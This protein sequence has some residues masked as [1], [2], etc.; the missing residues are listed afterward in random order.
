VIAWL[1]NLFGADG[2]SAVGTA[3]ADAPPTI[4]RVNPAAPNA[5]TALVT[6]FFFEACFTRGIVA[7][8]IPCKKRFESSVRNCTLCKDSTQGSLR[9]L[10][11]TPRRRDLRAQQLVSGSMTTVQIT[12]RERAEFLTFMLVTFI[13]MN[14]GSATAAI[15]SRLSGSISFTATSALQLNNDRKFSARF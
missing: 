4:D 9:A 12:R 8:S 13:F 15:L 6:C 10:I 7:T 14:T 11:S 1:S 2:R 5:G 3:A